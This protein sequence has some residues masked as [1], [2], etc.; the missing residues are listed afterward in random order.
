MTDI[1]TNKQNRDFIALCAVVT[2]SDFEREIL[3]INMM[4][5]VGH[6]HNSENIKSAIEEMVYF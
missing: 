5:M 6:S 4:R 1:W 3:V 2:N